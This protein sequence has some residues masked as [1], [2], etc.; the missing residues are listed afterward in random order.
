MKKLSSILFLSALSFAST[1]SAATIFTD[2]FA[3]AAGG[4]TTLAVTTAGNFTAT[5]AN[6]DLISS[7][8][9]YGNLCPVGKTACVD[10]DG[11]GSGNE[12]ATITSGNISLTPGVY[13]LTFQLDGTGRG[14]AGSTTVSLGSFYNKTIT[15][16]P[17]GT[18]SP[19]TFSVTFTVTT[20]T[21]APIVFTSNTAGQIGDILSSVTLATVTSPEPSTAFLM[22]LP[23]LAF[24]ALA[25][26][27]SKVRA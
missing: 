4:T 18:I 2:G 12:A 11:T 17:A 26:R 8:G 15:D 6:V 13:T 7:G 9:N 22:S 25:Y 1:V 10:L 21:S 16:S 5:T 27:R 14:V 24:G 23:L 20:A 19:D 3:A